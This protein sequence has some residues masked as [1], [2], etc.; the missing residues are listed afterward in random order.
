MTTPWG[1]H[2]KQTIVYKIYGIFKIYAEIYIKDLYCIFE[3]FNCIE[4][5]KLANIVTDSLQCVWI[6]AS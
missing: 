1:I 2:N 3:K 4:K 5:Q 6:L